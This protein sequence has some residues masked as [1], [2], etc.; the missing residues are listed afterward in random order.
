MLMR[1]L[2]HKQDIYDDRSLVME[3]KDD[4]SGCIKSGVTL[5]ILVAWNDLDEL[6][7]LIKATYE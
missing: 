5:D 1:L 7:E 3:L 4:H 6:N 2:K